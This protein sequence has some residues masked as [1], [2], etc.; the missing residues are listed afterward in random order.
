[1][2]QSRNPYNQQVLGEFE[3]LSNQM[4]TSRLTASG[5]AFRHWKKTSFDERSALLRNAAAVLTKNQERYARVISE[6][7]GKIISESRAE[8]KKCAE[9]CVYYADHAAQFLKDE[10]VATETQNSFVSYHPTGAILAIMPWNF[11]FWQV[12]RFAA[13]ALMAGN[14]A[15]LKHSSN[16]PQ[17]SIALEQL[18]LEAGFPEATFQSLLID[19]KLVE[20]V[21]ASDIVQGV[22]LTGSEKAGSHVASVAGKHIKTSVLE[23]GGSDP[24]IVLEDA[25]LEKT[26]KIAVQSR[27]QNA[28]QSCIAAKRFI[29]SEKIKD[30]FTQRF[31]DAISNIKQGDQFDETN[32]MGPMA[33]VDLAEELADQLRRTTNA[34]GRLLT[35][36][37]HMGANFKPVLVDNVQK[38]MAAFDEE[39]FGPLAAVT[40]VQNDE[41]AIEIANSSRYG[42]GASVWT[43]DLERGEWT[44]RRIE[45]GTVYVNSLMRSDTRLPFGGIKKSGYG[46]ELA[47]HG[48][49]EFVNVKSIS[50]TQ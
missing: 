7:M 12:F 18:F 25:D 19:N 11:P 13:P 41:E 8:V 28:G 5:Q 3:E 48:I 33:R 17:C 1:M 16:V 40:Y 47:R 15:L 14:V 30:D 21:L 6:E 39:T 23:L 44:A 36:G 27:M 9:G 46:R 34:G 29:V 10:I 49:M 31:R 2:I 50:V 20:S 42:L 26:V 37:G 24:F 38:G 45:A 22:A 35:G 32:T 43:K 4:L